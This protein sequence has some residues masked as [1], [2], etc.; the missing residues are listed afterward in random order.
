M[1]REHQAKGRY[2]KTEVTTKLSDIVMQIGID[3]SLLGVV[4]LL[5]E[6]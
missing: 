3:A 4:Y 2:M 1:L 5:A 6:T